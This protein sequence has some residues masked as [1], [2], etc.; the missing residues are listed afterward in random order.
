MFYNFSI[1]GIAHTVPHHI[2]VAVCAME[3]VTTR[4]GVPTQKV[5][6][7]KLV[8]S[9]LPGLH[10]AQARGLVEFIW[11]NNDIDIDGNVCFKQKPQRVT[12]LGHQD[13]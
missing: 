4:T 2:F 8:R 10:E 5:N 11:D 12:Y 1:D 9:R 13:F 6:A 3:L 7:I